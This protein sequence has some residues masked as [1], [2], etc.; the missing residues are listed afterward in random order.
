MKNLFV[1]PTDKPSRLYKTGDFLLLDSKAI[2]NNALETKNQHIY[3]TSDEEIKDGDWCL[4]I[5]HNTVSKRGDNRY[6]SQYKKIILTTNSDLIADG[7]QEIS[8]E[9]L[10]W[11][12]QN[13]NCEEVEVNKMCHGALSGFAD[14]GYKIIIPKEI[15]MLE[16]GQIIPK[17]EA[18]QMKV[19]IVG[20][21]LP[22][23]EFGKH[24]VNTMPMIK[25]EPK[26][27]GLSKLEKLAIQKRRELG[28][29]G[30]IDGFIAGYKLAQERSYTE[31]EV[32]EIVYN[33]IGE[34][35][36]HYGIMID[37]RKLNQLF[38]QFKKK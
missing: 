24:F 6:K 37:G 14:S 5:I 18:K 12:V 3:I 31:E 11:F 25:E 20:N 13:P 1:L 7:V 26:Q 23:Q 9:F 21:G 33:I 2:P 34:Y 19:M 38:E 35:G 28:L 32:G 27:E 36:K 17:E 10:Q 16:L 15:D 29:K 8:E 30:T 4:N 22:K